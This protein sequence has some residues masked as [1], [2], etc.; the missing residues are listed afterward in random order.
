MAARINRTDQKKISEKI[1]YLI[2][3]GEKPNTPA[4]RKQAAGE[5]YGMSRAGRLGRHGVYHPVKK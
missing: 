3:T 1:K 2:D 5:A 4:G